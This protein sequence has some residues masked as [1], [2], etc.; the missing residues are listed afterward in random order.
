[1]EYLPYN[2][3]TL[4]FILDKEMQKE[5]P[6]FHNNENYYNE[7]L[8]HG[9]IPSKYIKS[10]NIRMCNMILIKDKKYVCD[11]N[12]DI[13]ARN[14]NHLIDMAKYIN[15]KKL[16]VSINEVVSNLE[17]YELDVKKLMK[18]KKIKVNTE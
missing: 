9:G 4:D 17:V 1:M 12:D 15:K 13:F 6:V 10:L 7:Y 2:P 8:V 16:D 11:I 14:Y 18:L 5:I 3:Y